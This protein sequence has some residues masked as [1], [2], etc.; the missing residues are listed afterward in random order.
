[1]RLIPQG[2]AVAPAAVEHSTFKMP[3]VAAVGD[4][5][6]RHG[7]WKKGWAKVSVR[8]D[9][10]LVYEIQIN[11]AGG[12]T[13]TQAQVVRVT[14]DS[15]LDVVATLFSDVM[16]RGPRISVRGTASLSRSVPPEELLTAIVEH[17]DAYRVLIKGD[18]H[19]QGALM[20][21]LG[22]K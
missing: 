1:M 10:V 14:T 13:F 5:N 11:D 9:N 12:E 3:L 22:A 4:L 16:I 8:R 6:D 2:A 21:F 7:G 20:G 17:P 18:Q 19:P 15:T